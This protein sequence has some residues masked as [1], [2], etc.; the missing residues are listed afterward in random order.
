MD[1]GT[2]K[3]LAA[4]DARQG[5]Q[6][7]VRHP[8]GKCEIDQR[9]NLARHGKQLP[10]Q[11]VDPQTAQENRLY[12]ERKCVRFIFPFCATSVTSR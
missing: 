1:F 4:Q 2:T 10:S 7:N 8:L 5:D 12:L 3:S 11:D 6:T 9:E